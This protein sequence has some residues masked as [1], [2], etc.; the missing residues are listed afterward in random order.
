MQEIIQTCLMRVYF[1]PLK[2]PDLRDIAQLGCWQRVIYYISVLPS[3]QPAVIWLL[4]T[5]E[6]VG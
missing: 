2:H 6:S 5:N 4:E 3:I 1:I